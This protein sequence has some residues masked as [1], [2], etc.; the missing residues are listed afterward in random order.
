MERASVPEPLCCLIL[1]T[2]LMWVGMHMVTMELKRHFSFD[3]TLWLLGIL[4]SPLHPPP[5]CLHSLDARPSSGDPARSW[6]WRVRSQRSETR[7]ARPQKGLRS[8][9]AAP[10]R[11]LSSACKNCRKSVYSRIIYPSKYQWGGG[12]NKAVSRPGIARARRKLPRPLRQRA[13]GVHREERD[14]GAGWESCLGEGTQQALL[15]KLGLAGEE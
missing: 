10:G 15:S 6:G 1:C 12:W 7:Q 11:R 2:A 14:V 5:H 8:P 13:G 3:L 9:A 4:S